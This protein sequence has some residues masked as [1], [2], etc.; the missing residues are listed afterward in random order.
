MTGAPESVGMAWFVVKIGLNAVKSN[1][2]LYSLFGSGL[3]TVTEIM[4]LVPHYDE[5][6]H[7]RRSTKASSSE[8]EDLLYRDIVATYAAVLDFCFAIKRHLEA[9]RLKQLGHG[10]QDLFG[11][12]V[13]KFQAKQNAIATLKAKVLEASDGVFK[14]RVSGQLDDV[15]A[16]LQK[17]LGDIRSFASVATE[18]SESQGEMLKILQEMKTNFKPKT[19]WDLLKQEFEKIKRT[20]DPLHE[21]PADLRRLL[22]KRTPSTPSWLSGSKAFMS[23]RSA[24]AGSL[25]C[26]VR[27]PATSGPVPL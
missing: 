17:S 15:Q 6:F 1:Y 10:F 20:L 9:S 12:F 2:D 22:D 11:A 19:R 4:I 8:M 14:G 26:L 5:L 24:T 18:L 21:D 3:T 13:T 25:L 23:W 27:T 7:E 16:S